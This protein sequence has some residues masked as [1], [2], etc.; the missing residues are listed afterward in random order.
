MPN[1]NEYSYTSEQVNAAFSDI[2]ASLFK[3][4]VISTTNPKMLIV[5]GIQGSGKTWLL[6]ESLLKTGNYS[7]YIRLYLPEYR[8]KHPQYSRMETH[9]VL[10]V[11]EHT[12]A[13]VR[14][15]CTKIFE[16]AFAEKYSIIMEAALDSAD[17]AAFPPMAVS[18]GYQ[19]EVHVVA[20]KKE[21]TH[22]STITRGLKSLQ[23]KQLER[24]LKLSELEASL[25]NAQSV[26]NAFEEACAQKVG[27]EIT[28]YE[29]GFGELKN[30]KVVC[31]SQCD[32][33]GQLTPQSVVDHKGVTI[34]IADNPVAIELAPGKTSRSCYAAYNN[35][36][37][38]EVS[39]RRDRREM[40][41]DCQLA[42]LEAPR[43]NNQVPGFVYTDLV[44]YVFKH[45]HL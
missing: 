41:W 3:D 44:S 31:R 43:L 25:G 13:F 27:S 9:G 18:A 5:A 35:I 34:A 8:K 33:V 16:K 22:L 24:F 45:L 11:Y 14:E 1:S 28:V 4:K 17:F 6:E 39:L 36:V 21:F 32:T 38:A 2:S 7:N 26:L 23:D 30:R 29:R 37:S 40:V 15:V 19:F 10:H 20:C 42:L 12:E